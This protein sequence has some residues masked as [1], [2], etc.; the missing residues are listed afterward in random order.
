MSNHQTLKL[1]YVLE[2]NITYSLDFLL[3]NNNKNIKL[4]NINKQK[5]TTWNLTF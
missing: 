3:D 5:S 2:Y 1:E 4:V